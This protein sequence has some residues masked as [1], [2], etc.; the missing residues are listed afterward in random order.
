[1]VKLP[2]TGTKLT[3]SWHLDFLDPKLDLDFLLRKRG[4]KHSFEKMI[5]LLLFSVF[6]CVKFSDIIVCEQSL[7]T[8]QVLGH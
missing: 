5:R 6:T 7:L 3:S 4:L 1:M 2:N 8:L